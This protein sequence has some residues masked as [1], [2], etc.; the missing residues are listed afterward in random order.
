MYGYIDG[1]VASVMGLRVLCRSKFPINV[2]FLLADIVLMPGHVKA[3][4]LSNYP[5]THTYQIHF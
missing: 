1:G 3:R 5:S 4:S 2:G